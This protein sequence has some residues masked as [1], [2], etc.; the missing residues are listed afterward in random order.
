MMSLAKPHK[1]TRFSRGHVAPCHR[2]DVEDI[3]LE[4]RHGPRLEGALSP[5]LLRRRK[6]VLAIALDLGSISS[7]FYRLDGVPFAT[8]T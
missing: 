2:N 6:Q 7:R 8:G 5:Q 4:V 1:S 3:D